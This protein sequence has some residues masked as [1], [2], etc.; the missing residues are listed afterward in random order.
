LILDSSA[1]IAILFNEPDSDLLLRKLA[2][3]SSA[4]IG[5]PTLAEAGIVL[6]ARAGI[7]GKRNLPV[8]L[9]ETNL[10]VVP[11]GQDHWRVAVDAF[12]RFGKGQHGAGL[13]FGDCLTYATAKLA[14]LPL[15]CT[16]KDFAKTD[17]PIA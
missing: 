14:N 10:A 15:L 5:A 1:L 7:E 2:G 17:L 11:F 13:N 6:T 9:M 16:G 4:G 3:A 12:R 8:F